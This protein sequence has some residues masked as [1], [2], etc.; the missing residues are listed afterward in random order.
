VSADL[1]FGLHT[2]P[3][4]RERV[5]VKYLTRKLDSG[6]VDAF[7]AHYL[8]CS[9]CY[10]ELRATELLIY[11]LGQV[12]VDRSMASDVAIVRFLGRA[13]LTS[14]S[15]DLRALGHTV[16]SQNESKVLIDLSNVSRIDS[17]GLGMLMNCYCHAVNN[18]GVLK[19]LHPNDQIKRTL[20]MTGM[21]SVL[22][23]LEDEKS[24]LESFRT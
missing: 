4:D 19:L 5:F 18:R 14:T 8:S 1:Y 22:A 20:S 7:E 15:F 13:Q 21:N 9:E 6:E 24:A 17:T 11:S 12:V 10:E 3:V 2:E 16:R 23:S